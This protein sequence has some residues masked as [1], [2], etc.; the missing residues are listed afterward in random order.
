MRQNAAWPAHSPERTGNSAM[1]RF[2]H[3]QGMRV[4]S[5]SGSDVRTGLAGTGRAEPSSLVHPGA[6]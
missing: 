2:V 3:P 4:S 1:R 5:S 6:R